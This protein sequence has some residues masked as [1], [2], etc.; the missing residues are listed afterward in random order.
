VSHE[1]GGP[2]RQIFARKAF[3]SLHRS[4]MRGFAEQRVQERGRRDGERE[5][6]ERAS[7]RERA[8][9][10]ER[11]SCLICAQHKR[12]HNIKVLAKGFGCRGLE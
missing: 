11:G 7:E 8:R 1:L 4:H 9:A 2:W 6:G 3:E 5:R 10:R 12:I